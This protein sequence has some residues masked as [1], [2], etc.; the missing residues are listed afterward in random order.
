MSTEPKEAN[1]VP[2]LTTCVQQVCAAETERVADTTNHWVRNDFEHVLGGLE[3]LSTAAAGIA[4]RCILT[5]QYKEVRNCWQLLDLFIRAAAE[6]EAYEERCAI[7]V[8]H[9]QVARVTQRAI[10]AIVRAKESSTAGCSAILLDYARQASAEPVLLADIT[11]T[12]TEESVR[13]LKV[14]A[15]TEEI[16]RPVPAFLEQLRTPPHA[17]YLRADIEALIGRCRLLIDDLP[18][19]KEAVI[20][21]LLL[22]LM[23]P[24]R[25]AVMVR[26]E[27]TLSAA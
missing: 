13:F 15:S 22:A 18:Q 3:V 19:L 11:L 20:Y 27:R 5:Q 23:Q 17:P 1:E 14:L 6:P 21:L 24:A 25:Q 12:T 26:W 10:Q 2:D 7:H 9:S 16:L 4:T 8:A